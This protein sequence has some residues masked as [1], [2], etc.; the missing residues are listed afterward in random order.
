MRRLL[1][2]NGIKAF[3]AAARS[4]SFAAAGAELGVRVVGSAESARLNARY[5]GRDRPTNVLSFPQPPLPARARA[6]VR[7]LGDLVICPTVLRGEARAQAKPLRA[8]WAPGARPS[9]LL[10][11]RARQPRPP[12]TRRRPRRLPRPVPV[13]G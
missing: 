4:G 3:E 12:R 5:R 10:T 8:H 13:A 1:F 7:A 6:A 2:L 9:D 11:T